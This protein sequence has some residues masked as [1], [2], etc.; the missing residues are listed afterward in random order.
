MV[1]GWREKMDRP[2]AFALSQWRVADGPNTAFS[3]DAGDWEGLPKGEWR[4]GIVAGLEPTISQK[5]KV[6]RAASQW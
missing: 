6:N 2:L 4:K 1:A 5:T 3:V